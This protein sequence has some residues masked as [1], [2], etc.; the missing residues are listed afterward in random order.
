MIKYF[1]CCILV[2]MFLARAAKDTPTFVAFN[3]ELQV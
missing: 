2:K 3:P 1:G